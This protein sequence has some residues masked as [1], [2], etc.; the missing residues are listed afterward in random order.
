M[1]LS[2]CVPDFVLVDYFGIQHS[3][4]YIAKPTGTDLRFHE[5]LGSITS[6]ML[7]VTMHLV[8]SCILGVE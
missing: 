8:L 4:K 6:I 3:P 5:I 1:E 2:C 7:S